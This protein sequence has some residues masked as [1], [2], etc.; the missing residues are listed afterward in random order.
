MSTKVSWEAT[1]RYFPASGGEYGRV[2]TVVLTDLGHIQLCLQKQQ[3]QKYFVN[4]WPHPGITLAE[5]DIR[6][7]LF[8]VMEGHHVL[9]GV[10]IHHQE[11]A[12][13]QTHG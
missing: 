9:Q 1:A 4:K 11:T 7:D 3:A 6:D 10:G 2:K 13:V 12:V 8:A 5:P